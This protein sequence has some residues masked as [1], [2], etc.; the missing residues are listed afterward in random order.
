MNKYNALLLYKTT[1]ADERVWLGH[2]FNMIRHNLKTL[3]K[4]KKGK[5]CTYHIFITC[6]DQHLVTK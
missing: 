5:I 6:K 2:N 1:E 3:E 4:K